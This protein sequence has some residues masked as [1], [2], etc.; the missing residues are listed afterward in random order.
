MRNWLL[1]KVFINL[2]NIPHNYNNYNS[3][4]KL[5][6]LVVIYLSCVSDSMH[7]VIL[8]TC[9][10]HL[11][12]SVLLQ[13]L[14]RSGTAVFSPYKLSV[15]VRGFL[16]RPEGIRYVLWCFLNSTSDT[17]VFVWL[18]PKYHPIRWQIS[19]PAQL[20]TA[21]MSKDIFANNITL[22]SLQLFY[23]QLFLCQHIHMMFYLI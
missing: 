4:M 22:L 8:G 20:N 6:Y 19:L 3:S 11:Y 5:R 1:V 23:K 21:E 12:S 9:L 18:N 16:Q 14:L 2:L 10:I 17:F 7:S 15:I 13:C